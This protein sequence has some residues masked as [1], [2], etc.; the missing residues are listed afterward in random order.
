MRTT[1]T[2]TVWSTPASGEKAGD[3]L[4]VLP[5]RLLVFD[6]D[7]TLIDSSADLC[8]SV[9]AALRYVNCEELSAQQITSFIGHGAATLM[10]RALAASSEVSSRPVQQLNSLFDRAFAFFLEYYRDHK[11]DAT[12]TYPGV[13]EA[14]E[15][16][17]TRNPELPMAVLTNKPV[18]PSREICAA[19]GLESYFFAI[20][21]GDSFTKK[22]DPEG[23]LS[24]IREANALLGTDPSTT[25]AITPASVVV[26]GDSEVDVQTARRCRARVLGCAYG[27]SPD[28][29]QAAAPDLWATHP[30]EWAQ[31]LSL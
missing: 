4:V 7:G 10:R 28:T 5:V 24:I 16:L 22:P 2:G 13:L 1:P 19:L 11:L 21:G 23:L 14:L 27:L 8:S 31:A 12:K 25:R 26:I 6:L 20:Y 17:R 9:N 30:S 15:E 18:R 29:L 3:A